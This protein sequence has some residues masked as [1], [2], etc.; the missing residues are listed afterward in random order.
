M[1]GIIS[2]VNSL[3]MTISN[4]TISINIAGGYS[5]VLVGFISGS[6]V[7]AHDIQSNSTQSCVGSGTLQKIGSNITCG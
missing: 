7:L 2:Y 1:G 6:L 4:V 5:G 3:N